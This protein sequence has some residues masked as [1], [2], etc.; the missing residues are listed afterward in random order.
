M[1]II[2]MTFLE[3]INLSLNQGM[4]SLFILFMTHFIADFMCQDDRMATNKSKSNRWLL[5]HCLVYSFCFVWTMSWEFVLWLFIAHFAT[6]YI[7]SR[8]AST[9]YQK[10]ERHWFFVTI[11]FDQLLHQIQILI[12]WRIFLWE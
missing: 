1:K 2:S 5:F 8:V 3:N 11:G 4:N 9:L 6:D 10:G 12:L 7:T